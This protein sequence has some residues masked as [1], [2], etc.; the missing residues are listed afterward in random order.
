MRI[1]VGEIRALVK[2]G[3][4]TVSEAQS[5]GMALLQHDSIAALYSTKELRRELSFHASRPIMSPINSA[6]FCFTSCIVAAVDFDDQDRFVRIAHVASQERGYG[7]FLYDTVMKLT[8]KPI[9]PDE[10][11]SK[12]AQAVWEKYRTRSDVVF[13]GE[14]VMVTPLPGFRSDLNLSGLIDSHES[15]IA[16]LMENEKISDLLS[17]AGLTTFDK[18]EDFFARRCFEYLVDAVSAGY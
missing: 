16:G 5:S 4:K 15:C 9:V 7:S 13:Q 3:M 10:K 2:E 11:T 18:I 12:S 6:K 17:K 14:P 8:E 1:T